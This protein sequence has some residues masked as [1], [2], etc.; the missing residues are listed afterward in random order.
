MY[1]SIPFEQKNIC[2]RVSHLHRRIYVS[3]YLICT[4][5][6]MYTTQCTHYPSMPNYLMKTDLIKIQHF[7]HNLLSIHPAIY[8]YC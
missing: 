5:E 8:I 7:S 3:E 6:H 4:E 1:Q 2:I